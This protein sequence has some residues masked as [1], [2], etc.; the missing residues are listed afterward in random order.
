[1][2]NDFYILVGKTPKKVSD[3]KEWGTFYRKENS[4]KVK[5][6][7]LMIDGEKVHVSTVFLALDH[8]FGNH[9]PVLF[10][11]MIFGGQHDE[12]QERYHTYEEAEDGHW[13]IVNL[14]KA[15]MLDSY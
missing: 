4:R 13:I 8:A 1:M 7:E 12:F 3:V 14:L 15:G 11:T 10:E 2:N 9:G 6:D 5:F